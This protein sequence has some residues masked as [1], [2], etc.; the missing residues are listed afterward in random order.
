MALN[1]IALLSVSESPA[2]EPSAKLLPVAPAGVL[3]SLKVVIAEFQYAAF[4]LGSLC[5]A[6][7]TGFVLPYHMD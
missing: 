1:L 5:R 3:D 7:P 2:P 4:Q 6:G